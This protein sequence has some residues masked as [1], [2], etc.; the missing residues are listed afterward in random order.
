M[1]QWILQWAIPSVYSPVRQVCHSLTTIFCVL[2][3]SLIYSGMAGAPGE[4]SNNLFF[5]YFLFVCPS[6]RRTMIESFGYYLSAGHTFA[7]PRKFIW[8]LFRNDAFPRRFR[9]KCRNRHF[10]WK[11][12]SKQVNKTAPTTNKH[13]D[14]VTHPVKSEKIQSILTWI[15]LAWKKLIKCT[16]IAY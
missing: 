16:L 10:C 1:P 8:I 4:A 5:L 12:R 9:W 11:W 3:V 13:I 6:T 2:Y 15:V 14:R 7:C